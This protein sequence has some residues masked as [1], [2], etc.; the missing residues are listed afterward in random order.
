M[1]AGKSFFRIQGFVSGYGKLM[2]RF[3]WFWP[4]VI[5]GQE[6]LQRMGGEATHEFEKKL[7]PCLCFQKSAELLRTVDQNDIEINKID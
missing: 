4:G 7:K 6:V 3:H 2:F 1:V 5:V